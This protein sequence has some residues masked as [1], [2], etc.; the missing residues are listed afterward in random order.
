MLY[1][2]QQNTTINTSCYF[3]EKKK[4][5]KLAGKDQ[6][7][8]SGRD[9]E[10]QQGDC[11]PFGYHPAF[12]LV[13]TISVLPFPSLLGPP[14]TALCSRTELWQGKSAMSLGLAS[15]PGGASAEASERKLKEAHSG[16]AAL[17]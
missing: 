12:I 8:E 3:L 15:F 11:G 5:Q 14:V 10:D 4:I 16:L 17:W 6:K 13:P 1:V 9:P 7:L 2:F